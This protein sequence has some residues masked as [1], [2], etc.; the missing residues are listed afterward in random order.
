METGGKTV[1]FRKERLEEEPVSA[2]FQE[3]NINDPYYVVP[4][5]MLLMIVVWIVALFSDRPPG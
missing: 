3:F 5:L 4:I 2:F 1:R